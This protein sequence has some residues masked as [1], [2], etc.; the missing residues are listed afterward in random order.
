M[1]LPY[2]KSLNPYI[3]KVCRLNPLE[4]WA[5]SDRFLAFCKK[6]RSKFD[7]FM[8]TYSRVGVFDKEDVLPHPSDKTSQIAA[9]D[10]V[11]DTYKN[12]KRF[13]IL[14][15]PPDNLFSSSKYGVEEIWPTM[16]RKIHHEWENFEKC[17][18]DSDNI[19]VRAYKSKMD[20]LTAVII[21][22]KGTPYH[23]GL[24]FI[25]VIFREHFPIKPPV[26]PSFC[27]LIFLHMYSWSVLFRLRSFGYAINPHMFECGEV[28]LNLSH[29]WTLSDGQIWVPF[30]TSLYDLLVNIRD[31]V[32][33][34]DPLFLQPGFVECGSSV[35]SEYFSF[36]YN[37][38]VLIKSLKIMTCIMNKPPKNFEAFVIGHFRNRAKDI[39]KDCTAFV[40][41]LKAG[42][43]R[44]I[45]VAAAHMSSGKMLLHVSRNL[46]TLLTKSEQLLMTS[47][48]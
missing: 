35:V 16:A 44:V 48:L 4:D 21:G 8:E 31:K 22:N 10:D 29:Q 30:V 41:G 34:A 43:G 6:Y 17:L 1:L 36:L 20:I 24:F 3:M 14:N 12:F 38:N 13:E 28:R 32:L 26:C 25:D 11:L 5:H 45:T 7:E 37:E 27:F 47:V 40:D 42:N 33:N 18:K 2:Q 46:I 23:D 9:V 15:G 19:Y 39:M